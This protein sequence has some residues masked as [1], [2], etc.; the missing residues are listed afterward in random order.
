MRDPA[1]AWSNGVLRFDQG[2]I[3][4]AHLDDRE[5]QVAVVSAAMDA[6]GRDDRIER[7]A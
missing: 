1:W 2:W 6:R 4:K 5:G 3:L 7:A